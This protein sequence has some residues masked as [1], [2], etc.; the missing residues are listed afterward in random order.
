MGIPQ[1]LKMMLSIVLTTATAPTGF[2]DCF[3]KCQEAVLAER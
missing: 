1:Y 3:L 2:Q